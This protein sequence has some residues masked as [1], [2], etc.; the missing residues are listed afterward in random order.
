MNENI[1]APCYRCEERT[2]YCHTNCEKYI[3]FQKI[4]QML[5]DSRIE[6]RKR[7][8]TNFIIYIEKSVDK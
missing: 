5:R 6:K 3:E 2:T 8:L 1:K 4:N 7:I